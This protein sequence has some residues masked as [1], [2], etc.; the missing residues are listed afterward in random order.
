MRSGTA[1]KRP[2]DADDL[3]QANQTTARKRISRACDRCRVQK[4][5]CD[6]GK[7]CLR[8]GDQIPCIY[9][10]KKPLRRKYPT[11]YVDMLEEH[12]SYLIAGLRRL[13]DRIQEQQ[14]LPE[15]E[16]DAN[17]RPIVHELLDRLGIFEESV[18]QHRER[19]QPEPRDSPYS[20]PK[21]RREIA[22]AQ[23]SSV[24]AATTA[25]ARPPDNPIQEFDRS[26]HLNSRRQSLTLPSRVP[27]NPGVVRPRRPGSSH[28]PGS[29]R[30]LTRDQRP[31]DLSNGFYRWSFDISDFLAVANP[32]GFR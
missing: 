26:L 4:A 30:G 13:Y 16:H 25:C 27:L 5:R 32:T 9:Q 8:C 22:T 23:S 29:R 14:R 17:D 15:V 6:G 3:C 7:P 19:I 11:G 20:N 28:H 18:D 31:V 1:R 2:S 24:P 21:T 12:Q 10:E